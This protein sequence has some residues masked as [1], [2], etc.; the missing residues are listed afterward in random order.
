MVKIDFFWAIAIYLILTLCVA[1]GY[2]IFY[3]FNRD[4]IDITRS[5]N[6]EQCPYCTH[7]FFDYSMK[8]M[9]LCPCCH[10]YYETVSKVQKSS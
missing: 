8:P 5:E 7:V 6:V 2:W 4:E 9:K 3:N 1:I 10:S